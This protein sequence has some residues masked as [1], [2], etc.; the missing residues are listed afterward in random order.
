MRRWALC[1]AL[2]AWSGTAQAQR[3]EPAAQSLK[4]YLVTIGQGA[5]YWE[6]YGHNMLWFHDQRAGIDAAYNWGMFDFASPDFLERQLVGDPM[7]WVQAFPGQ[8]L[9]DYYRS[10]DRGITLQELNL[11]P[12]Q[13]HKALERSRWS[14]REE[15]KFYRYD[16]YKDN[17][18]TRVRDMIDYALG[19]ALQGVAQ[20][21]TEQSYRGE[22]VRLLADLKLTQL[23]TD[24]ALGRP[25][26]RRLTLWVDMFI[27]MRLRDALRGM[28]VRDS[29]GASKPVVAREQVLYE[30]QRYKERA[31]TPT[32]R[33][34]YLLVGIVL[35][36]AFYAVGWAGARA[37][38]AEKLFR[39]EVGVWALLVGVLGMILLVGWVATQHVFWYR[40][41]NLFLVNPLALFLAVLAPLSLWR[42]RFTR[43]AA[44]VATVLAML[45]A[46]A[47]VMKGLPW[48]QQN[49]ALIAMF[50]PPHFVIA[51]QLWRRAR[52]RAG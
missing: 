37:G 10:R 8:S 9:L 47:L 29:S 27:P 38:V 51:Y 30:G 52:A 34:P 41:E 23:G 18:S 50:L 48:S 16:Y 17:C 44:I 20:D 7:Y 2:C 46:V 24:V 22:T 13:A 43:A 19:G 12:Q 40:N 25:A 11:T 1:L 6:K 5:L 31:T 4:V 3:Q 36:I 49:I 42:P 39:F 28:Q 14:A 15:N 26:D 45:S 32:R 21:T 33:A 35:A